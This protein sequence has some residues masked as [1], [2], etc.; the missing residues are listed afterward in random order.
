M[1]AAL[2]R[3]PD[4]H[5]KTLGSACSRAR[6]QAFP[7]PKHRSMKAWNRD[8]QGADPSRARE[9]AGSRRPLGR[10]RRYPLEEGPLADARG[11]GPLA[12]AR[13]SRH[14]RGDSSR[15]LARRRRAAPNRF[16]HGLLECP[17]PLHRDLK[18]L[19]HRSNPGDRGQKSRPTKPLYLARG[20]SSTV[21]QRLRCLCVRRSIPLNTPN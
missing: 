15:P 7:P 9:R 1:G 19:Q 12:Y 6:R 8:R 21:Q 2:L 4:L 11:S 14:F 18:N 17:V 13:G 10:R 5:K 20:V 3:R 16:L